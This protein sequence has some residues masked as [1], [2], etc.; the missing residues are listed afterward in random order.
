MRG[1]CA[2]D[3]GELCPLPD[4]TEVREHERKGWQ[5]AME[6]AQRDVPLIREFAKLT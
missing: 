5:A 6:E 3:V 1:K 2:Y 4:G